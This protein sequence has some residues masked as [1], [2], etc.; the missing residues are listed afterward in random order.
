MFDHISIGVG[1]LAR[2]KRFYDAAL[3]PLGYKCLRESPTLLGY[4]GDSVVLW[5]SPTATPVPADP[6]SGLHF[7]FNAPDEAAVQAFHAAA[8]RA[9]GQ[10]NGGPGIRRE[11]SPGYYAA[12]AIDPD[13]Y[14]IEAYCRSAAN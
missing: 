3:A 6:E 8:L 9:G 11:Y 10:D 7:C 14:R 13:G 1:D 2:T 5:I 12:F 4:G